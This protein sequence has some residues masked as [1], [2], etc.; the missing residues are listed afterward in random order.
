MEI[1]EIQKKE[2]KNLW[3]YQICAGKGFKNKAKSHNTI[4]CYDKPGNE[5]KC[6]H[7][8]FSQKPFSLGPSKNKNQLFRVWLMKLLKEDSD[9]PE[10]PPE[11]VNVNS[12][13]I[14]KIPNPIS[15][16]EKRK[17]TPKLDSPL[18]L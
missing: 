15:P 11:D 16:S 3:Y 13:S 6:P 12:V 18:G 5:N 1:D 2:G 17:R 10:S 8:T 4:D 14:E 7:K 9:D